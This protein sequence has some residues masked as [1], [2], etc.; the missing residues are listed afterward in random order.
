MLKEVKDVLDEIGMI[1]AVFVDE[2][3]VLRAMMQLDHQEE[4][5]VDFGAAAW[6]VLSLLQVTMRSFQ[7]MKDRAEAVERGVGF[8]FDQRLQHGTIMVAN[9]CTTCR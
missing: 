5:G 4:T 3:M 2:E 8:Q 1:Q 7:N 9:W 6:R